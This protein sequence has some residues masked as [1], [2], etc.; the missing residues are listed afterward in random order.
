MF[1]FFCAIYFEKIFCLA[2]K[3]HTLFYRRTKIV[4]K[5]RT[6]GRKN[7]DHNM[8]CFGIFYIKNIQKKCKIVSYLGCPA[9]PNL[10]TQT[11]F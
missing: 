4:I 2:D 1:E 7:F 8:L 11:T 10:L 6:C 9:K 3:T 5:I